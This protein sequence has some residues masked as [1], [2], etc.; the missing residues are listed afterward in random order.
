MHCNYFKYFNVYFHK[1]NPLGNI[2]LIFAIKLNLNDEA[3]VLIDRGAD[4]KYRISSLMPCGLEIATEKNDLALVSILVAGYNRDLY[5]NWTK[6]LEVSV[7]LYHYLKIFWIQ[8]SRD[9]TPNFI[10]FLK[11]FTSSDTYHILKLD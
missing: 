3:Q 2:T 9:C 5:F 10:P 4:P 11:E 6:I 1:T 8:M 7:R